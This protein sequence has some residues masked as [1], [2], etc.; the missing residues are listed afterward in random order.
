MPEGDTI[1][2]TARSLARAL[3][4]RRLT[5]YQAF[6]AELLEANRVGRTVTAVEARGKN[7]L[8]HFDDGR[9]LYSHMVLAGSW[10]LYRPGERWQQGEH[11][12][13]AVL[14]T[15]EFVAVCFSAPH[16]ELLHGSE[17]ARHPIL[18][19][20]GP[21][22]LGAEFAMEEAIARFRR[23]ADAGADDADPARGA[24]PGSAGAADAADAP[25]A[26]SLLSLGEALLDQR[27]VAGVGN[28]WKSEVLFVNRLDPFRA[29]ASVDDERLER[30]LRSTR[31]LMQRNLGLNVRTT[32]S[33]SGSPLWVYER[34]GRPCFHC[35]TTIARRMQGRPARGTY[36]C[37]RC[38]GVE[39]DT[40]LRDRR[41]DGR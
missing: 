18:A 12:A 38:Q 37:A 2:R 41:E 23:A 24:D 6:R 22:L 39:A 1:H 32:R 35:R 7:L 16:L 8:I 33:G 4:G 21:D 15:E 20:L 10:H 26:G 19:A 34:T 17:I 40:G 3:V 31:I 11:L 25:A 5:A 30:L 9:A 27:I 36:Y 13:R 29:V 28:V 14:S